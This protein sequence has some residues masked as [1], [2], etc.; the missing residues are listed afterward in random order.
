MTTQPEGKV[1]HFVSYSGIKL[2]LKLVNE[3]TPENSSNRNTFY[4]GYFN[5]AELLTCCQKVV[6]GEIESEHYYEYHENGLIKQARIIEDDDEQLV[7]FD[8]EGE[9][10]KE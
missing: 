6:Y 1:R 4:R 8:Q 5:E 7:E 9:M 2:P 3:L 10:K